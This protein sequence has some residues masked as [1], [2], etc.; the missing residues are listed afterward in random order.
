M[1][2]M[3]ARKGSRPRMF[4]SPSLR[5]S[6]RFVRRCTR[7][8]G[9]RRVSIPFIAGQ[10][11]LVAALIAAAVALAAFQSPSL[12]GSGRLRGGPRPRP[13]KAEFQSPSLRGS[14]RFAGGGRMR[15]ASETGFNPLH[16][17]AVVAYP[18]RRQRLENQI[19]VSIPFIAGQWSLSRRASTSPSASTVSIPFI[20]GQWSLACAAVAAWRAWRSFNPL[21]CGAVVA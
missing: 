3:G 20:A 4:Q 9:D 14:G 19:E 8:G 7:G 16:C 10:W 1:D 5:G 11:S 21:H 18:E 2:G 12:R 6:G 17:G 15:P 13:P